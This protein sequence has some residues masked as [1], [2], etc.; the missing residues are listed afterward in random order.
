MNSKLPLFGALALSFLASAVLAHEDDPKI[1]D[2]Q[3]PY[4]GLGFRRSNLGRPG[5]PG[6]SATG[7]GQAALGAFQSNGVQLLSWVPLNQ[8]GGNPQSGSDCWGYTSPSGREYAL[9][10]HYEGTTFIEVTDPTNPSILSYKSGPSSLWRDIKVFQHMAYVVSEGG[11]GIQLFD[12]S[13]IDSGAI[14]SA[15]TIATSG[16]SRTHNVAIN[17]DSGFLYRTGGGDNGLRVYDLNQSLTNPPLVATWSTRYVHDA[18][19]V[20][21]TSGPYAGKEVAFCCSGFNGGSV[22]TG[23]DVLDVTNKNNIIVMDNLQYSNGAYSHQGWLS[24]DMQYFYLGDELDENG[25][26]PTTTIVIDVSNLNNTF[27]ATTF[28]NGNQSIGHNL[29][30]KGDKILAANY[31][32]GLRVFDASNPLNVQEEAFFDTY[33]GSDAD[34]FNGLWSVYP[35]FASGTVIG[36]D[37]ERGLF[38]WFVGDQP[39][40]FAFVGEAPTLIDPAGLNVPLTITEVQGTLLPGTALLHYDDGSGFV[41]V[42]LN[43]QSATNFEAPFPSMACGTALRYYVSADSSLGG[44]WSFPG[45]GAFVNATVGFSLTTVASDDME[46]NTGWVSG[47]AGDSATTGI[48]ERVNPI[49]TDAQPEDDHSNPGTNCWVTGQGTNGGSVGENDVD[50]GHTTLLSPLYDAT[51]LNAPKISYWRWYSNA[52]NGTVDDEFLVEVTNDGSNWVEVE[53]LSPDDPETT[54]G[55]FEHSFL[56]ADFVLPT[57]SV[58]LRFIAEDNG[59][60][61]IVEA[62][63][64]D[65]TITDVECGPCSGVLV[66]NYCSTSPNSVGGG[67][68][69]SH[70]GSTS[71]AANDFVLHV[72][73]GVPSVPGLVFYGATQASTPLGNGTLCISSSGSGT[74]RLNPAIFSNAFGESTRALDLTAF[75]ANAGPGKISAGETWNFQFWYRDA[76]AGG[77]GF[78]LSDALSAPFCP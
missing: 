37:L 16:E 50:G 27:E 43:Q 54:G 47:A 3:A 2:L 63:I 57:N 21:Y 53:R 11:S 60:G 76:A 22:Q 41:S 71:I 51:G 5:A 59:S 7:G 19:I 39:L 58:R 66:S 26:L 28:T 55:W 70:S 13:N 40:D 1:L 8:V 68:V 74:F 77:A 23:L 18:Q 33:P 12:M 15:G 44:T 75:P 61:S 73:A 34:S 64:D 38:V 36:S 46:S 42:P 72:D 29:Y 62:A 48:W 31:R 35:Y 14:A 25:S 6:V 67:A 17:E 30:T 9:F 78:N 10:T 52:S 65:L 24:D 69:I 56:I 20:S 4:D 32:S 45:G 49:G